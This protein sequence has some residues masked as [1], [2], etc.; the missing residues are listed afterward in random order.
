MRR[1]LLAAACAALLVFIAGCGDSNDSSSS[2]NATTNAAQTTTGSK[3]TA[4]AGEPASKPFVPQANAICRVFN[5]HLKELQPRLDKATRQAATGK[6]FKTYVPV[7]LDTVNATQAAAYRFLHMNVPAK[8]Q[9][10]AV[11]L[12][13]VMQA[14]A[15]VYQLMLTSAQKDDGNQFSAANVAFQQSLPKLLAVQ[16]GLGQT[17]ICGGGKVKPQKG[18]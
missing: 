13:R 14:Q 7:M 4:N 5:S 18:I 10:K 12:A 1:L 2:S 17:Y 15:N 11:A 3:T 9:A 6:S 16:R 8:E